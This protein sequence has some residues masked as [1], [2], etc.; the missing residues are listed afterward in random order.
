MRRTEWH[1]INS[2]VAPTIA[3]RDQTGTFHLVIPEPASSVSD[4]DNAPGFSGFSGSAALRLCFAEGE[5]G[6]FAGG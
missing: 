3:V 6:D 2:V 4:S 5:V 1:R